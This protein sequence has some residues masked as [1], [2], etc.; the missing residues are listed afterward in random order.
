MVKYIHPVNP[1]IALPSK[2]AQLSL[3]KRGE[4]ILNVGQKQVLE[5]LMLDIH[6]NTVGLRSSRVH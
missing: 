3:Q 2:E 6:G 4:L 1:G 5:V